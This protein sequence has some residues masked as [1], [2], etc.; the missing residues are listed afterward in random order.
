MQVHATYDSL[1][2]SPL[3]SPDGDPSN[4]SLQYIISLD[5]DPAIQCTVSENEVTSVALHSAGFPYC[6]VQALTVT[7]LAGTATLLTDSSTTVQI[8]IRDPGM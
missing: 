7:P 2:W 5:A 6:Q 4:C 1:L 3:S 8:A